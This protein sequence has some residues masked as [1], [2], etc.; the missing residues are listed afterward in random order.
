[1]L[2]KILALVLT[3][4]TTILSDV[5]TAIAE[6]KKDPNNMSKAKTVADTV[7]EV[8]DAIAPFFA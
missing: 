1:M 2:G 4:G 3:G 5:D 6:F 8:L 7:V